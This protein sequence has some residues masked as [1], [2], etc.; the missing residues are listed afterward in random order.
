MNGVEGHFSQEKTTAR[1]SER[2]Y[3]EHLKKGHF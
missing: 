3:S 1:T 2:M